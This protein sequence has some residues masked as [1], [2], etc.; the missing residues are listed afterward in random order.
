[1]T[2][3]QGKHGEFSLNESVGTLSHSMTPIEAL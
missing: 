2:S 3:S 1:M